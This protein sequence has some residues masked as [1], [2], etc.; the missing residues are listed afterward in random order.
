MVAALAVSGYGVDK[1]PGPPAPTPAVAPS[2]DNKAFDPLGLPG[3]LDPITTTSPQNGAIGGRKTGTASTV[4]GTNLSTLVFRVQIFTAPGFGDARKAAQVAE[5]IFDKPV[6][7]DYEIPNF[8]VR[9]GDFPARDGAEDYRRLAISMG[10]ANCWV[11]PV[12]IG[13]VE[14]S[15]LYDSLALPSADS[16]VKPDSVSTHVGRK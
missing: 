5:E 8:K 4:S 7:I 3:D 13:V 14:S 1:K 16:A 15:P 2:S 9:V 6:H 11:V 10:Y 12:T